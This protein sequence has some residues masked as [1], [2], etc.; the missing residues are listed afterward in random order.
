[1]P[2]F[3]EYNAFMK[4]IQHTIRDVPP[5]VDRAL[6]LRANQQGKSLNSILVQALTE[7]AGLSGPMQYDDLDFLVGTW[8]E[9]ARFAPT[10]E[11]FERIDEE[12]WK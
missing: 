9:E 12:I 11:V 1:M 5:N 10:Q 2:T 6:R 7:A 3:I 8:V 4:G